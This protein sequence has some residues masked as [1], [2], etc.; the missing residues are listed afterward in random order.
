MRIG[1]VSGLSRDDLRFHNYGGLELQNDSIAPNHNIDVTLVPSGDLRIYV[2]GIIDCITFRTSSS[3]SIDLLKI[4]IWLATGV[5]PSEMRLQFGR[6]YNLEGTVADY[7]I[8][9]GDKINM[10]WRVP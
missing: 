10:Q 7:N 3:D 8:K 4:K 5:P 2:D 6:G 9:D 1:G